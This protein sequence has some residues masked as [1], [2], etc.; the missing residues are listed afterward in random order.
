MALREPPEFG[1]Y[2]FV[3][4]TYR[5]YD[6]TLSRMASTYDETVESRDI[7]HPDGIRKPTIFL[8]SQTGRD[9]LTKEGWEDV[10]K[11]WMEHHTPAPVAAP[12]PAP[13]TRRVSIRG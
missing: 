3:L 10:T 9:R 6:P 5:A 8:N 12:D 1:T 4:R 7:T 11:G 2:Q 13:P